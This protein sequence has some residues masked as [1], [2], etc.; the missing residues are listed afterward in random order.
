MTLRIMGLD[1]SLNATGVCLPD[2][3]VLTIKCKPEWGDNRLC[4]IRDTVRRFC[5]TVDMAVIED[6]PFHAKAAGITG[7]VQ[8]A[9]R[10][11]LMDQGVPYVLI[12]PATLKKFATGKGNADKDEMIAAARRRAGLIF[13]DH[14]QCDAW[15]LWQ[16]G[17]DHYDL[18]VYYQDVDP[19]LS[20][21][22]DS[23][24]WPDMSPV[25]A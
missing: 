25:R 3:K 10:T 2:G 14:N 19:A 5:P 6:L 11:E 21:L 8:G 17:L 9:V 18:G 22:L 1:L 20:A 13:R 24:D 7:M 16:A 15:H 4:V 23:V 12:T